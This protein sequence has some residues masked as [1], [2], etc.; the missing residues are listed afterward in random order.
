MSHLFTNALFNLFLGLQVG[1]NPFPHDQTA[2]S[3]FHQSRTARSRPPPS[4]GR[5]P[6]YDFD[7][8][9]K[10][11]YGDLLR[12]K[13]G[14]I[15]RAAEYWKFKEEEKDTWKSDK[16]IITF[17]FIVFMSMIYN[18]EKQYDRV[19]KDKKGEN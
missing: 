9:S 4:S 8:W 7:E 2:Y 13:K 10:N 15:K 18:E 5:V 3:K 14:N 12:R 11:H 17:F 16:M 1:I 6:I 19:V